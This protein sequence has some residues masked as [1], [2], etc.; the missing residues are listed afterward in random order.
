M[1]NSL[2]HTSINNQVYI[3]IL[4]MFQLLEICLLNLNLRKKLHVYA[5]NTLCNNL[6]YLDTY[7]F[8]LSHS[9]C[10]RIAKLKLKITHLQPGTSSCRNN[11]H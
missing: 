2:C 9:T 11:L 1:C 3:Y 6:M 7:I 4:C 8:T 10:I 5:L